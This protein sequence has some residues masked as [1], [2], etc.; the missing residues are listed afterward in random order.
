MTVPGESTSG[1]HPVGALG[2]PGPAAAPGALVEE[3]APATGDGCVDGSGA[4]PAT[5]AAV[6]ATGLLTE[7]SRSVV[8]PRLLRYS[9]RGTV[10]PVSQVDR[11]GAATCPSRMAISPAFALM[12][13][14]ALSFWEVWVTCPVPQPVSTTDSSAA[15]PDTVMTRTRLRENL[16]TVNI[17][18]AHHI[19]GSAYGFDTPPRATVHSYSTLITSR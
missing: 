7:T 16:L 1:C 2:T 15:A 4:P 13:P 14:T 3:S 19:R 11:G 8:V 10:D 5:I 9:D 18:S 17:L 6:A 12:P